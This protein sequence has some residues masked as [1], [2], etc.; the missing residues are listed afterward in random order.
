VYTSCRTLFV[1]TLR[2]H[3]DSVTDP[4][5][6]LHERSEMGYTN[7]LD[8]AARGEPEAVSAEVQRELTA[9]S[10]AR[11]RAEFKAEWELER[12]RILAAVERLAARPFAPR[13]RNDLGAVR[14]A[15]DRIQRTL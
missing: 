13:I 2:H 12:A 8:K 15:L 6:L 10:H 7:R 3:A 9:E 4:L 1:L 14:A 5:R 11:H